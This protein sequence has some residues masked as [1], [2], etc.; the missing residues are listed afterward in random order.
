MF[1]ANGG[2]ECRLLFNG[3]TTY[4]MPLAC[5]V[6]LTPLLGSHYVPE[7]HH[8]IPRRRF[9]PRS[10]ASE[11]SK[12]LAIQSSRKTVMPPDRW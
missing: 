4:R 12:A 5:Q 9:A 3:A 7:Y 11:T 1:R 6:R 2:A 10:M 8:S